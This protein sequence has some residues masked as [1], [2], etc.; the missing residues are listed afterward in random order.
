MPYILSL[1]E[2]LKTKLP[3]T[4]KRYPQKKEREQ[5]TSYT[6]DDIRIEARKKVLDHILIRLFA[7]T[8]CLRVKYQLYTRFTFINCSSFSNLLLQFVISYKT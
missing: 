3:R 5:A 4:L 7:I 8:R 6:I 2:A 1:S